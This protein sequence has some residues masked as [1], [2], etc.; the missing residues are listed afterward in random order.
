LTAALHT[1]EAETIDLYVAAYSYE[2]TTFFALARDSDPQYGEV[3]GNKREI[4]SPH[5]TIS[6]TG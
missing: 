1:G 2:A 4:G 3:R 5:W 6:A